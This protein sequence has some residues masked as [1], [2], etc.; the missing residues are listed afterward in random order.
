[1][2]AGLPERLAALRERIAAAAVRAGRDPAEVTL[3][4]VSKRV[5]PERIRAAIDA[6]QRVFGENYVQ[7]ALGK[8]RALGAQ[9]GLPPDIRWHLIGRLQ[10]NKA[11]DAVAHFHSIEVVDRPDLARELDRRA[12]ARGRVVEVLIQVNLSREPQKAG[13]PEEELAGL[14]ARCAA[15]PHLQVV[16]LMTLPEPV[17]DPER[18]RPVFARLRALRDSLRSAPGGGN[19]RELSMG[20]SADFEVAVEEGAT[21][22]R[23]GTA[24]FGPRAGVPEEDRR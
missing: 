18:L 3:V 9:G 10:R 24:L 2:T 5:S 12:A 1:M 23:V 7:E 11:R 6:G 14:L 19:L 22:V 15:L 21:R 17:G 20:M 13:V 8:M 4:A 16:G